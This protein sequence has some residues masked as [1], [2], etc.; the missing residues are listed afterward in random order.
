MRRRRRCRHRTQT[1]YGATTNGWSGLTEEE[2]AG[3]DAAR[4]SGKSGRRASDREDYRRR[5][6]AGSSAFDLPQRTISGAKPSNFLLNGAAGTLVALGLVQQ[7]GGWTSLQSR[8]LTL[9]YLGAIFATDRLGEGLP[10]PSTD[11]AMSNA[12]FMCVGALII[13]LA[14]RA[15]VFA[16]NC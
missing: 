2:G 7:A 9:G 5:R 10:T 15:S 3:C 6:S 16:A 8:L 1:R 11:A 14:G 12:L 13:L 4:R